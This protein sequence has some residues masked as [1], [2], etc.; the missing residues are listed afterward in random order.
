MQL[1]WLWCSDY[2]SS[3]H[4]SYFRKKPN[5][6]YN[7]DLHKHAKG[8]LQKIS[9]FLTRIPLYLPHPSVRN[10]TNSRTYSTSG[11]R[12]GREMQGEDCCT[13]SS[14]LTNT[15]STSDESSKF[16]VDRKKL[17]YL[18]TGSSM[19]SKMTWGRNV[20]MTFTV[21]VFLYKSQLKW[22]FFD[23]QTSRFYLNIIC[24]LKVLNIF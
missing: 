19:K 16:I 2:G 13:L 7:I 11:G 18:H 12:G 17:W 15:W 5:K 24:R 4:I 21:F 3:S 8:Q 22:H 23:T 20:A 14:E 6:N 10:V 1:C 9:E